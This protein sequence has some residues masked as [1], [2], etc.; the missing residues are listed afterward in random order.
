M[1]GEYLP[2]YEIEI[3]IS[4]KPSE[5]VEWKTRKQKSEE[6][7]QQEMKRKQREEKKE[8]RS[9]KKLKEQHIT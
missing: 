7:I 3:I 8:E 6:K 4:N 5:P 1:N 9:R 2:K